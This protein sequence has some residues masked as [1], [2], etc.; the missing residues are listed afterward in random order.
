MVNIPQNV[1]PNE[2]LHYLLVSNLYIIT[3]C[4][5]IHQMLSL[6]FEKIHWSH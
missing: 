1:G 3:K 6:N 5:P 2:T 4:V